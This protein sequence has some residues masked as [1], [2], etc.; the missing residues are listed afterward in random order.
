[1]ELGA[2]WPSPPPP[3]LFRFRKVDTKGVRPIYPLGLSSPGL[4]YRARTPHPTPLHPTP[5]LAVS[6]VQ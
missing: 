5:H 4:W 6:A 2:G 3:S 1:M